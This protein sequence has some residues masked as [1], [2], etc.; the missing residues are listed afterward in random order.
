[1]T[2]APIEVRHQ[3]PFTAP[4]TKAHPRIMD[5]W[6]TNTAQ[7]HAPRYCTRGC[8]H[9]KLQEQVEEQSGRTACSTF[10][11]NHRRTPSKVPPTAAH[12]RHRSKSDHSASRMYEIS[13]WENVQTAVTNRGVVVGECNALVTG[14]TV[15]T[16]HVWVRASGGT[17][18]HFVGRQVHNDST[19]ENMAT[20]S[21]HGETRR[22]HEE[23]S[24][25]C[26]PPFL[27]VSHDTQA[28][29]GRIPRK[30]N[31][32]IRN[33]TVELLV[34]GDGFRECPDLD[35]ALVI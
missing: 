22:R 3:H 9:W 4:P 11:R 34:H 10:W 28:R 18:H 30:V 33:N 21:K 12:P 5:S 1:M 27:V 31:D 29:A 7:L 6:T 17:A 15:G 24:Q 8:T 16:Q 14:A 13:R 26:P 19:T 23:A 32:C 25:C 35:T 20:T 2:V